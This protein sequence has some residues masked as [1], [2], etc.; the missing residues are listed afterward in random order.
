MTY[1]EKVKQL[2]TNRNNNHSLPSMSFESTSSVAAF[3]MS[4]IPS[5]GCSE[6]S[7]PPAYSSSPD[8]D[9]VYEELDSQPFKDSTKRPLSDTYDT[10]NFL[11]PM[12]QLEGHYQS[13]KTLKSLCSKE[14]YLTPT[15]FRSTQSFQF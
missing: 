15:S 7:P 12:H 6:E 3:R 13:T 8:D 1:Q 2:A 10:L 4:E 5:P 9:H 14:E 11:R